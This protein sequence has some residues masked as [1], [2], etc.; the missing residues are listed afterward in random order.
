MA[1]GD[2]TVVSSAARTTAGSQTF[3]SGTSTALRVQVNVSAASG[4]TPQLTVFV[5]DTLDG[6]NW[7][8]VDTFPAVGVTGNTVRNITTVF[9]NS[10]RVRWTITGTTPSFTF[11]VDVYQE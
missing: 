7:N 2:F 8:T 6:T 4:T 5:E 11:S 9:T 10:C 1:Q 3:D